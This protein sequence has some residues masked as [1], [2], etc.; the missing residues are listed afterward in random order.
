MLPIAGRRGRADHGQV[1]C[2]SDYGRAAGG[3]GRRAGGSITIIQPSSASAPTISPL[4]GTPAVGAAFD[5]AVALLHSFAYGAADQGFAGVAAR[6]LLRHG[7]PG[8]RRDPLPPALG[9]DCTDMAGAAQIAKAATLGGTPTRAGPDRRARLYYAAA[10]RDAPVVRAL[11]YS[12]SMA[13]VARDNP[14]TMEIQVFYAL[15]LIATAPAGRDPARM[16]GSSARRTS[17]SLSGAD[18]LRHP[19][20][21][22]HHPDPRL[23]Q[24]RTGPGVI[25]GGARLRWDRPFGFHALHMPSRPSSPWLGLWNDLDRLEPSPPRAAARAQGDIGEELQRHGPP[26]LR[27]PLGKAQADAARVVASLCCSGRSRGG[28]LQDRLCGQRHA[29]AAGVGTPR[30]GGGGAARGA[31]GIGAA[32]S[33]DCPGSRLGP[34][35]RDAGRLCRG[36]HRPA[37]MRAATLHAPRATPIGRPR[38]TPC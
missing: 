14:A 10:D 19:G 7:L 31:A 24:R 11:R 30:L 17:W 13:A 20:A 2:R 12:D 4:A 38:S 8:P 25:A 32:G 28:G 5:R 26:D 35:A 15:S 6:D 29:G 16:R 21:P 22:P 23:R 18:S 36:R 34:V 37:C 9:P 1:G 27:L 33:R 3:A